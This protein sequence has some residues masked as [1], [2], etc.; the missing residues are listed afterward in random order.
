MKTKYQKLLTKVNAGLS[1][2]D[3]KNEDILSAIS[4]SDSIVANKSLPDALYLDIAMYRFLSIIGNNPNDMQDSL[5]KIAIK[6]LN[7]MPSIKDNKKSYAIKVKQ[8]ESF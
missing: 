6:E 3:T 8:R 7:K 4:E 2:P 1:N 5:Y